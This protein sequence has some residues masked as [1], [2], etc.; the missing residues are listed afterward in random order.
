M[1]RSRAQAGNWAAVVSDRLGLA[2]ETPRDE[3]VTRTAPDGKPWRLRAFAAAGPPPPGRGAA[4]MTEAEAVVLVDPPQTGGQYEN[5]ATVTDVSEFAFCPRRYY[6]GRYLG[7]AG[8]QRS[9]E[10][11]GETARFGRR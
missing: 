2:L 11:P 10:Q 7:I 6:L 1:V 4:A 8:R 5:N 9:F 3:V